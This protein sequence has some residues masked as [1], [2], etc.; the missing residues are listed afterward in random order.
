M[1]ARASA[2][3][4]GSAVLIEAGHMLPDGLVAA[5][6]QAQYSRTFSAR[7]VVQTFPSEPSIGEGIEMT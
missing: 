5:L 4:D 3:S 1:K 2:T 6:G 7:P